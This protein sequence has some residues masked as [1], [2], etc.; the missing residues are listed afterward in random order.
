MLSII[1]KIRFVEIC[2]N[3]VLQF[4][5]NSLRNS[6]LKSHIRFQFVLITACEWTSLG[7]AFCVQE[8]CNWRKLLKTSHIHYLSLLIIMVSK[9]VMANTHKLSWVVSIK[10][11]F[12][13][14]L[15]G[16]RSE[17]VHFLSCMWATASHIFTATLS[18]PSSDFY[19]WIP[20]TP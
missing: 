3:S 9:G 15:F 19:G 13:R 5:K 10:C 2:L 12:T 20:K 18:W 4:I 8:K 16:F 11:Y 1:L 14:M 7:E 17:W 6:L